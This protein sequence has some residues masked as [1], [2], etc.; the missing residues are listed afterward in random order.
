MTV[1]LSATVGLLVAWIATVTP[2]H[3]SAAPAGRGP[4]TMAAVDQSTTS[5]S[6][7]SSGTPSNAGTPVTY[8]A[9]VVG[10]DGGGTV[11]FQDNG[12]PIPGCTA[13]TLLGGSSSCGPLREAAGSHQIVGVYSGDVG[14]LPST[15]QAFTQV[16]NLLN[17]SPPISL[18]PANGTAG[19]PIPLITTGGAGSGSITFQVD[20]G[21]LPSC[22]I[23]AS[24]PYTID[25]PG[26]GV[27]LVL[28]IKASD[29]TYAAQGAEAVFVFTPTPFGIGPFGFRS[30]VLTKVLKAKVGVLAHLIA[31]NPYVNDV[32]L[33][34]YGNPGP[35]TTALALARA[36]AVSA[37]LNEDL[38]T[39]N[40]P[41]TITAQSGGG[42]KRVARPGSPRNRRVVATMSMGP[43]NVPPLGG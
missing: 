30:A 38:T 27:C 10:S 18:F 35:G 41:V 9:T 23:S 4:S 16:V 21:S 14:S 5:V 42:L 12:S 32:V 15:S 28:A 37:L 3:A 29:G 43:V 36:N 40:D 13:Q 6:I 31:A 39:L 33:T 25:S 24:A 7:S 2:A 8:T 1:K 17:Q 26:P 34:G 20:L 22:F 11:E 19:V